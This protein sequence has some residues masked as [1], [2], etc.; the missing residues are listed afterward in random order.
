MWIRLLVIFSVSPYNPIAEPSLYVVLRLGLCTPPHRTTY[1]ETHTHTRSSCL[2]T[3]FIGIHAQPDEGP[4]YTH[5]DRASDRGNARCKPACVAWERVE[6]RGAAL[7]RLGYS[8]VGVCILFFI[9]T[10][11]AVGIIYDYSVSQRRRTCR[12]ELNTAGAI[13]TVNL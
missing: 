8:I 7:C 2:T 3:L 1:A 6:M 13:T 11:N 10:P 5:T 12:T 4:H 9:W